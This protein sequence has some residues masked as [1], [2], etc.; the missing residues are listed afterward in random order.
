MVRKHLRAR[1]YLA[2]VVTYTTALTKVETFRD[3]SGK[4]TYC[5]LHQMKDSTSRVT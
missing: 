3:I 1:D 2:I 5:L 4:R